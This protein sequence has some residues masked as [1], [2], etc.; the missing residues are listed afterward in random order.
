MYKIPKT[1]FKWTSE[2][3]VDRILNTAATTAR[4]FFHRAGFLVLPRLIPKH[5]GM[6]ALPPLPYN[7]IPNF[8]DEMKKINEEEISPLI[9]K[10]SK[11]F[12]ETLSNICGN[13]CV[14]NKKKLQTF[15]NNWQKTEKS[16]W[17]FIYDFFPENSSILSSIEIRITHWG[18]IASWSHIETGK[19]DQSITLY[20]REDGNAGNI[21]EVILSALVMLDE[22]ELAI[23]WEGR[24]AISDYLLKKSVLA[25]LFPE[26]LPTLIDIHC[27]NEELQ[28]ESADF[29]QSIGIRFTKPFKKDRYGLYLFDQRID[30][31]LSTSHE[32]ILSLLIAHE[33]ETVDYDRLGE[34]L[35]N[36]EDQFSLWAINKQ[37]QRL[38]KKI[39]QLGGHSYMIEP[40]RGRGYVLNN[41][42]VV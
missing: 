40:V 4:G 11:D 33:N 19:R 21:A 38:A 18:T 22:E 34:T 42:S 16:F 13:Y 2:T 41:V 35:W 17:K 5:T 1:T 26:Y 7:T 36:D 39:Y 3:E 32:K 29:L 31:H 14:N 6:V 8:W 12:S 37:M 15:Q 24:E 20:I 23:P 28:K 30:H 10:V 27:N 9:P 25:K